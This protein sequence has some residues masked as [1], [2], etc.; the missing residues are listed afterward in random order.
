[1]NKK[2]GRP[3]QFDPDQA[4]DSAMTLFWSKGFTATSLDDLSAATNMNRPSLYNAFGDK[5]SIY[6]QAF[7]RFV[8]LMKQQVE[9]VLF[10]EPDLKTALTQFYRNALDVYFNANTPL[11]CFVT[12]TAPVEAATHPEIREDLLQVV[13][14][15]DSALA[16]R[17]SLAQK[18]GNW[19]D[20]RDPKAVAVML[21]ATLQS[22]AVRARAG[23]PRKS[24]EA[25]Y[26]LAV[27]TF[28]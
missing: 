17:L 16:R 11:G 27:D 5:E 3:R 8:D 1:M 25:I 10:S 9:E 23:E 14:E 24:L 13:R 4:L 6:R 19:P 26:T 2:R 22:I 20:D 15:V 12:C 21:H 28:C 18:E 7:S